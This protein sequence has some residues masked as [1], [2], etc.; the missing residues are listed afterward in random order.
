MVDLLCARTCRGVGQT[1]TVQAPY[2]LAKMHRPDLIFLMETK[3]EVFTKSKI[4]KRLHFLNIDGVDSV[5]SLG[6]LWWIGWNKSISS[7]VTFQS[8]NIIHGEVVDELRNRW[9]FSLISAPQDLSA[10]GSN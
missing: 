9:I 6:G 3:H 10:R 5:G 7:K 1:S 2:Q 8:P 4:L